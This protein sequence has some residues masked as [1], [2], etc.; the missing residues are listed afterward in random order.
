MMNEQQKWGRGTPYLVALRC[1]F[2]MLWIRGGCKSSQRERE[3]KKKKQKK[4]F[5]I[6]QRRTML[7]LVSM[8]ILTE[9]FT[10]HIL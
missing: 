8:I 1:N 10:E 5:L 9:Q 2:R 4:K 6:E 7:L 3:R